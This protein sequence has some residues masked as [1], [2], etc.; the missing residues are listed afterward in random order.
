M[1]KHHQPN[2]PSVQALQDNSQGSRRRRKK[3]KDPLC[4]HFCG[5]VQC[6]KKIVSGPPFGN[7]RRLCRKLTGE[8]AKTQIA[9]RTAAK[10][11]KTFQKVKGCTGHACKNGHRGGLFFLRAFGADPVSCPATPI[12]KAGSADGVSSFQQYWGAALARQPPPG[13]GVKIK[14][15]QNW[16]PPTPTC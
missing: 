8:Y 9:V 6:K 12:P 15:P 3:K 4:S 2:Q 14:T 16:I 13:G 1:R 10:N 5:H 7:P 11:G